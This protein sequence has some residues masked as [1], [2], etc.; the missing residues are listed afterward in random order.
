M[1]YEDAINLAIRL[2]AGKPEGSPKEFVVRCYHTGTFRIMQEGEPGEE[3]MGKYAE[4]DR[5]QVTEFTE[6]VLEIPALNH[7]FHETIRMHDEMILD[8]VISKHDDRS[9]DNYNPFD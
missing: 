2:T 9:D 8:H 1:T 5:G 7:S 6:F 3:Y 4:V